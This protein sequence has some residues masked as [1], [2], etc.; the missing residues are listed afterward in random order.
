MVV[1]GG[2]PVLDVKDLPADI[3]PDMPLLPAP[4]EPEPGDGLITL[5]NLAGMTAEQVEKEHIRVTLEL[6]HGNR[7]Q[8]AKMLAMGERTLY[9]KLKEYGLG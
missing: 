9:R 7:E 5:N 2:G 6:T 1:L 8:A 3:K 4:I